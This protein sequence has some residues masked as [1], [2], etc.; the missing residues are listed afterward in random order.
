MFITFLEK[1]RRI[2]LLDWQHCR[3]WTEYHIQRLTK[4][5]VVS[6]AYSLQHFTEVGVLNLLSV[7]HFTIS[8]NKVIEII[9]W[10]VRFLSRCPR[11]AFSTN[12]SRSLRC[13]SLKSAMLLLPQHLL[14]EHKYLCNTSTWSQMI[15]PPPKLH[16]F[17]P[18]QLLRGLCVHNYCMQIKER[19]FS[20]ATVCGFC[21]IHI[22]LLILNAERHRKQ[23]LAFELEQKDETMHCAWLM[24]WESLVFFLI[25]VAVK[26]NQTSVCKRSNFKY[27]VYSALF[28]FHWIQFN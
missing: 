28:F 12:C 9:I 6:N 25:M 13:P 8:R 17:F 10:K 15:N 14:T 22:L 2:S 1:Q 20:M 3:L 26:V 24:S 5:F 27:R 21:H 7:L 4:G 16:T 23:M 18:F 19:D 11:G